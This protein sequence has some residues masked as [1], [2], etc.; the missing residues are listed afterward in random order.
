MQMARKSKSKEKYPHLESFPEE[1]LEA[2]RDV[3]SGI[4][5]EVENIPED[6][7]DFRPTPEMRS[8]R[9]L[10]WHI[11]E[12]SMMMTGEL[13][14]PD[15][16][17]KRLPWPD[18]LEKYASAAYQAKS[19]RELLDILASQMDDAERKF[20]A[21]GDLALWQFME[22]FDGLPGTKVQW[23]HHGISQE[24][25]HRGQLTVYARL[26]GLVPALTQVIQGM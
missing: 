26:M 15:T 25:Y 21:A 3:R 24:M 9:E 22:R 19:K 23:L 11:L 5:S 17:M 14:R 6:K 18:L 2:W 10:I 4:I 8:V 16:N 20:R 7:F 12:V 13:T 1:T